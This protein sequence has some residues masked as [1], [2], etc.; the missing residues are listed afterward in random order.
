MRKGQRFY[1]GDLSTDFWNRINKIPYDSLEHRELYG[2]GCDLQNL[3][4]HVL[5]VLDKAERKMA[6]GDLTP[7]GTFVIANELKKVKTMKKLT[8]NLRT[9]LLTAV[10]HAGSYDPNE[11][12]NY[13][14]ERMTLA[15]YQTASEFLS[16]INR[17]SLTF[18][19]GTIEARFQ[20]WQDSK[21]PA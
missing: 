17:S 1:S 4:N 13:V 18:G 8:R 9:L 11:A 16:W 20:E 6:A 7:A 5:E 12:L 21:T 19:H 14:E 10:E 3:E 15:E 2:L